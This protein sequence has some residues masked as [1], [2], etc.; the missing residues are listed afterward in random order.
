M[1]FMMATKALFEIQEVT[2]DQIIVHTN[3]SDCCHGAV[4]LT[5]VCGKVCVDY[6]CINGLRLHCLSDI[7]NS[8]LKTY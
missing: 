2:V 5:P 6:A 7:N 3:P 8:K 4:A 1:V